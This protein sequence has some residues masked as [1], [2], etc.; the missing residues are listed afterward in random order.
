[1]KIRGFKTLSLCVS[2]LDILPFV[3]DPVHEFLEAGFT[4]DVFEEGINVSVK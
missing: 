1:L 3:F 4:S 2:L